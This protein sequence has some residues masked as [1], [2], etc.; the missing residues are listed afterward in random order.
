[1]YLYVE[2]G[3]WRVSGRLQLVLAEDLLLSVVLR[4][5]VVEPQLLVLLEGAVVLLNGHVRIPLGSEDVLEIVELRGCKRA[6][7]THNPLKQVILQ[8]YSGLFYS[9]IPFSRAV[10]LLHS[11]HIFGIP[12]ASEG[13]VFSRLQFRWTGTEKKVCDPIIPSLSPVHLYGACIQQKC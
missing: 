11:R 3:V 7:S 4:L 9:L 2:V 12:V 10:P 8:R 6:S 5:E 13:S 1:M